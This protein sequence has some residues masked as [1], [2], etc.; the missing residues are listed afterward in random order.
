MTDEQLEQVLAQCRL[1][2]E[3]QGLDE[4]T[5]HSSTNLVRSAHQ[6]N[7]AVGPT[8]FVDLSVEGV[9]VRAMVDTEAQSTI[10]SQSVLHEIGR[11]LQQEGKPRPILEQPT[12]QLYGKDGVDG[13]HRLQTTAQLNVTLEL[14]SKCV[15]K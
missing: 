2:H 4:S 12:V 3:Q 1:R 15:C 9:S 14:D 10:I 5:T 7:G 8:L 11:Q 13:G 6:E